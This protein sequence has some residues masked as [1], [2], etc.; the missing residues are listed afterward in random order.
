[1]LKAGTHP[2]ACMQ[3]FA[4]AFLLAAWPRFAAAGARL[5]LVQLPR[6]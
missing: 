3:G 4:K 2:R 1:M 5:V 6:A